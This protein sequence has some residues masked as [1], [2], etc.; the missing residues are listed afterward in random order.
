VSMLFVGIDVSKD[1][2]SAQGL[3][4]EGK[5]V[6][7]VEFAMNGE[8]FSQFLK[9]LKVHCKDLSGV[10]VGMESTGCYHINLFA[11][12]CSQGI[13]CVVINPLLISNFARLSL[14]KTKTDKKDALTIAQFL[15]AH[16]SELSQVSYS[17][18]SQDL[19]DLA[20][21]RESL[22][23]MIAGLKNDVRRLL[24]LTFPEL[25]HRCKLFTE[26]MMRFLMR[27]PSARAVRI[28]KSKE[29]SKA[30]IHAEGKRKRVLLS[31]EEIISLAKGSVASESVA[32]ELILSEKI[33]TLLYLEEKKARITEALVEACRSMRVDELDIVTSVDGISQITGSTFLAELGEIETFRSYKHVIAFAGL[34]PSIHQS[35]QYE[36][37]S[38]LSKR[39]NRHLR[40]VIFL[41]TLCAVRSQNIFREYFLKRKGEGLPAKKAILATAHKLLRVLFAMLSSKSYFRKEVVEV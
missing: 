38:R 1:Y 8:G 12:L 28:A 37:I 36:G 21:E 19:K 6:F 14:R 23:V 32:E 26:T 11:F 30:L 16:R 34:D 41:M 24:Q 29:I 25:E 13:V 33:E 4:R 17:Q 2:S 22:A 15:L 20:R 40:R 39:G 7:Y 31:S 5:K 3:D 35:G 18:S 10:T 27:F 9:L